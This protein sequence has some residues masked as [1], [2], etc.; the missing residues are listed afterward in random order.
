M[1]ARIT[2]ISVETALFPNI[3]DGGLLWAE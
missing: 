3:R 2:E 1:A